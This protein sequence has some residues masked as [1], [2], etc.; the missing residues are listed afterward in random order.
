MRMNA[1]RLA[2]TW[3]TILLGVLAL[4]S[5]GCHQAPPKKPLEL[6]GY[7][8]NGQGLDVGTLRGKPWVINLWLPG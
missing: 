5:S 3:M 8:L 4:S 6:T 1:R 7:Y 2:T